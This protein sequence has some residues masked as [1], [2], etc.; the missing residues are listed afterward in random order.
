MSHT[1]QGRYIDNEIV[2]NHKDRSL[3]F[4]TD[5]TTT[6]TVQIADP[7]NNGQHTDYTIRNQSKQVEYVDFIFHATLAAK[8]ADNVDP[9]DQKEIDYDLELKATV[10]DIPLT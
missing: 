6:P 4:H 3:S 10:G 1:V 7:E 9:L 2:N 5:E 8:T